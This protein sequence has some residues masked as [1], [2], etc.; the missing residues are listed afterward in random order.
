MKKFDKSMVIMVGLNE[1][2]WNKLNW[3]LIGKRPV[4]CE[5]WRAFSSPVSLEAKFSTT[6][7][8]KDEESDSE[9]SPLERPPSTDE[10]IFLSLINQR[11]T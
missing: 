10:V 6:H 4:D 5:R 2:R 11:T 8:S 9:T 1:K 7:S 3:V